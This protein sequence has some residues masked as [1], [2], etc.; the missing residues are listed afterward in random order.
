MVVGG[1]P[2]PRASSRPPV[3]VPGLSSA[4]QFPPPAGGSGIP[5][6]GW[7]WHLCHP[8]RAGHQNTICQGFHATFIVGSAFIPAHVKMHSV[9]HAE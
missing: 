9:P 1:E 8:G 5:E 4:H 2:P 3:G 6:K 7:G